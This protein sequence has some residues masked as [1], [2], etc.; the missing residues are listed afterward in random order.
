LTVGRPSRYTKKLAGIILSRIESGAS[1][2]AICR[3]D[4][5]PNRSIVLRWIAS[6]RHGFRIQYEEAC[7]LRAL[8]WADEI[9]DIADTGS[10]DVPRDRLSMDA[11]K[12]IVSKLL[13]KYAD[14]PEIAEEKETHNVNITLTHEQ[15]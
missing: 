4:G 14:K 5:M 13:P 1:V 10:G 12:W 15:Q 7:A 9:I 3:D 8:L 2:R 6:D 11:R